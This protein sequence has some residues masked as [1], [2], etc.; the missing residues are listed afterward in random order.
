MGR[1]T[2]NDKHCGPITYGK[3]TFN[4]TRLVLSSEGGEGNDDDEIRTTLTLYIFG[5]VFRIFLGNLIKRVT[6]KVKANWDPATI[7]RLGRNYYE[8]HFAKEYGFSLHEGFLQV[9]Y[10]L[11]NKHNHH[12]HVDEEGFI[13]Y[14]LSDENKKYTPIQHKSWCA[15]LPWTQWRIVSYCVYD[16][17]N[18]IYSTISDQKG[19]KGISY[20]DIK[21]DCPPMVFVLKDYDDT[22]IIAKTVLEETVYK[23][24]EGYFKWLSWFFKSRQYRHLDIEFNK[25]TGPDKGSWKGGTT[26]ISFN[27]ENCKNHIEAM[28][29]FCEEEHYSKNGKYRM[30]YI[31]REVLV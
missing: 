12:T 29:G 11:Q 1:L 23:L 25:E 17:K 2:D 5:Y 30:K 16:D 19:L 14:K 8:Y 20:Y 28:K 10:G 13:T 9:F 31:S 6:Y 7:A 21:K 26:G 24:G 4:A 27:A 22:E 18:E 3:T 15:H